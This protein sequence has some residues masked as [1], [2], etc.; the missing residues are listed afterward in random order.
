MLND[1]NHILSATILMNGNGQMRRTAAEVYWNL[2]MKNEITEYE[3]LQML[4]LPKTPFESTY[5]P[6][7]VPSVRP[8]LFGDPLFGSDDEEP[9]ET[10]DVPTAAETI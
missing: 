4:F 7:S 9:A 8:S 10:V 6:N 1:G 5:M 2:L 3:V